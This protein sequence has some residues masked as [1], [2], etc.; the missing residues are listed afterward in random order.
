MI[1][2]LISM[3]GYGIYVWSSFSFT[4]ASFATLYFLIKRQLIKEQ[5][6]FIKKF[7]R[8]PSD[9]IEAEKTRATY[10]EIFSNFP[11]SKI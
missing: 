1:N 5:N 9:K 4:L 7:S 10:K 11:V 2:E 3:N 6:K 8:L